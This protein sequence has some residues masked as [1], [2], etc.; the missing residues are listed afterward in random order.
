MNVVEWVKMED[1]AV[2]QEEHIEEEFTLVSD[3]TN[4]AKLRTVLYYYPLFGG[5]LVKKLS[6]ATGQVWWY[7]VFLSEVKE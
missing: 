3:I 6:N 5:V 7:E 2:P 4:A 1:D